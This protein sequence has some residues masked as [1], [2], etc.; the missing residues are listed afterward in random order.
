MKTS[1]K[2][3]QIISNYLA[4]FALLG[5]LFTYGCQK[6][7]LQEVAPE[8]TIEQPDHDPL[9]L[10]K[11]ILEYNFRV[12]TEGLSEEK[13]LQLYEE[14]MQLL[15]EEDRSALLS[16]FDQVLD[17]A[18]T[19][20]N[21][22]QS[23]ST[24]AV[25]TLLTNGVPDDG[26]G[27]GVATVGNKV[28][29]GASGEQK[30]YEFSKTGG[31]YTLTDEITPTGASDDFGT[32]VSVSGSWMAVS[33]PDFGQPFGRPG[34]LFLFKKQG[35]SWVQKDILTGP[36]GENNFS[37]QGMV[38]KGNKLAAIS[39]ASG[40]PSPGGTI[41]VF[42]LSGNN[43]SLSGTIFEPTYD[44][45]G[46][47]MDEGGNRIV[48]TGSVGNSLICARA[49]IFEEQGSDWVLDD[50]VIVG[51]FL[52]DGIAFPRDVAIQNNTVVLTTLI[53]GNKQYVITKNQGSWSVDQELDHPV[54]LPFTNRWA[55]IQGSTIIIGAA[56]GNNAVSD[57]VHVFKKS[58]GT[59]NYDE[60]LTLS[61]NGEDAIMWNV[62]ISGN[63]IVAGLPG[64]GFPP[65]AAPGK[66]YVFD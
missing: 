1:K 18:P 38:L 20:N 5:I 64:T 4:L 58:G 62:A 50:E 60:T 14:H 49:V 10:Q 17:E 47:D 39:S 66:V 13:I 57:A 26:F 24:R 36:A 25:E 22:S 41:S 33:A 59:W 55:E 42:E 7:N 32:H 23:I 53:P 51:C 65:P 15:P 16:M 8:A 37:G 27:Q 34:Q 56:S 43:W 28:Y 3:I 52:P 61:D 35:G 31:T 63:T 11:L 29:V 46:V 48:G 6:D 45:F 30:V 2:S 12:H 44:W 9:T 19:F 54:G 40:F 21:T